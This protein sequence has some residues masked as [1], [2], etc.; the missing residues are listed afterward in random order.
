MKH[1]WQEQAEKTKKLREEIYVSER[2]ITEWPENLSELPSEHKK[3]IK[4]C[5]EATN[6]EEQLRDRYLHQEMINRNNS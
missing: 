5:T 2:K 4:K 6:L 1:N 3:L